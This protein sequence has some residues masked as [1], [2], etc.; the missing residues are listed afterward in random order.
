MLGHAA[1]GLISETV[2]AVTTETGLVIGATSA[3]HGAAFFFQAGPA[4]VLL[5]DH[6]HRLLEHR[7]RR[8]GL[9]GQPERELMRMDLEQGG[10]V[11]AAALEGFTLLE[12][13]GAHF[14]PS[15]L[16]FHGL[17]AARPVPDQGSIMK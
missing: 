16:L 2:R 15:R 13:A 10:E 4:V 1:N 3:R 12:D 14:R 7:A 8:T 17:T 6:V 9:G 11:L 5:E